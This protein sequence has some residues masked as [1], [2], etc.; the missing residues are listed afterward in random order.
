MKEYRKYYEL[1][2][3]CTMTVR[4]PKVE[5][6]EVIINFIK[7]ADTE[8]QFLAREPEEFQCS[9]QSEQNLISNILAGNAR[10]WF[11]AEY[12]GEIVGQASIGYIRN[13]LRYYHRASV[14]FIVL[15][16]CWNMGI[17]GKLME[18]CLE[19]AHENKVEKLEL[20]VVSDNVRAIRMYEGFGF[21][22]TGTLHKSLKYTD[23]TYADEYMMELFL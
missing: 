15:K 4:F 14:A 9:V 21:E 6:A 7:T 19:W 22:K 18:S 10:T 5:D 11:I 20:D 17:G 23:G 12:N 13:N 16:K 8:S 3:G 2:N 1:K